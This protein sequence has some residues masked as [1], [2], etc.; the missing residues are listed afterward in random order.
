VLLLM[1]MLMLMLPFRTQPSW[2][3]CTLSCG[4]G[5]S[6]RAWGWLANCFRAAAAAAILN[7]AFLFIELRL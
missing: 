3:A 2:T 6:C 7:A 1:L 5:A 4:R